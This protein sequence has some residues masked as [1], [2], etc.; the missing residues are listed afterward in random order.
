MGGI[1][2]RPCRRRGLGFNLL[3]MHG[4]DERP[5][6]R[7]RMLLWP[8]LAAILLPVLYVAALGPLSW[9]AMTHFHAL[10]WFPDYYD[11]LIPLRRH[12]QIADVLFRYERWWD[13]LPAPRS[14]QEQ[15]LM[16][17]LADHRAKL[18]KMRAESK[19]LKAKAA[20]FQ[21]QLD[22]LRAQPSLGAEDQAAVRRLEIELEYLQRGLGTAGAPIH[23]LPPNW[24]GPREETVPQEGADLR[25]FDAQ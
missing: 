5:R 18:E 8:I 16:D 14:W 13:R 4:P 19:R 24:L 17:Q 11:S 21:R 9:W 20:E 10:K 23:S 25:Q 2:T 6:F 7:W 12:P 15:Y 3:P 22:T 1:T